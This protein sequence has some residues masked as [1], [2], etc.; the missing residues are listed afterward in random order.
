MSRKLRIEIEM[1]GA[2][3][4]D[5]AGQSTEAGRILRDLANIRT[6]DAVV[7]HPENYCGEI[8]LRDANGNI[9]GKLTVE[10][11]PIGRCRFRMAAR[12]IER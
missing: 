9:C 11:E 6:I 3:F 10:P 2:A 8:E 5:D 12:Q 1:K 4:S 7:L